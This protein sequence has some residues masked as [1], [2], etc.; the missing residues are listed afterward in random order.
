MKTYKNL[1]KKTFRRNHK[2]YSLKNEAII[3]YLFSLL[4]YLVTPLFLIF[5][6][7][8]NTVTFINLIIAVT[9]LSLIMSINPFFF[10]LGLIFYFVFRIL[11][12]CDG[13]IARLTN[14]AS[15]Y[16]RFLDAIL[17]I[18]YESF[19][20]LSIGYYCFKYFDSETLFFLGIFSSILSIYSTC[21][22]DKYSS[23]VRWMNLENKTNFIPYLRK[24]YLPRLGFIMSDINNLLIILLLIFNNN[25]QIF[26]ILSTMFFLSFI[27][28]SILNLSKHFY[29]ASKVLRFKADDKNTYEKKKLYNK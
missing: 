10:V 20:I 9:S 28:S 17:D 4:S 1:I 12:F 26:L 3:I 6:V 14:Q 25:A 24:K 19:L 18:F 11:D 21:M 7:R 5:K 2:L 13:N 15:F 8:P 23:L 16:G 22:H 29:S 27:I